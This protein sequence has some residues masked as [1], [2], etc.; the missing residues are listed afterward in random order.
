MIILLEDGTLG[1]QE[2]DGD[3]NSFSLG[4]DQRTQFLNG[5]KKTNYET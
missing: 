3:N 1:V 4:T 2:G 5:K